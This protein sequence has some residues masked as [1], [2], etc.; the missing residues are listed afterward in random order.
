MPRLSTRLR[1]VIGLTSVLVSA[2]L[3]A[4]VLQIAPD[5]R[6]AEVK[7]R[8]RLCE[9]LAV[10]SSVLVGREDINRVRAVLTVLKARHEDILSAGVRKTDGTL[11][12]D[13]GEHA[14]QWEV[15]QGKLSDDS[16]IYVPLRQ[17]HNDWG[18]LEMK[19][20]PLRGNLWFEIV[21]SRFTHLVL[22][23]VGLCSVTW[24]WFLGRV[25]EQLSPSKAVPG[26]VRSALDTL[27][28]GLLVLDRK[29][30]IVLCN[31]SLSQ[32]LGEDSDKLIGRPAAKLPW[33]T[34][35]VVTTSTSI[36][37]AEELFPW[38]S[39]LNGTQQAS[40]ASL[41]LRDVSGRAR[42]YQVNCAPVFGNGTQI[43]GVVC[44]FEDVTVLES[45]KVELAEA[46]RAKSEFLANMSHEIR[47]PMNAILGFTEVL[48]RGMYDNTEQRAEYLDTIHAS[49]NHLLHLI[50]DIL[51]LSKVESGR[52]ELEV[53]PC[54]PHEILL[55]VSNVLRVRV[56]EKGL[57][58]SATTP[59]GLPEVISSD[60][61][62]LRQVFTNLI[63]NAIK[64]TERGRVQLVARFVSGDAPLISVDVIDSG[65]GIPEKSL[66]KIFEPFTQADASVTRKFGGTGLGLTISK[67]F[68]EALG[69]NVTVSSSVGIGT[70]FTVTIPTGVIDSDVRLIDITEVQA[71]KRHSGP[72]PGRTK[73]KFPAAKIL[74]V[75]DGESNRQLIELILGREGLLVDT[76]TN[77]QEALDQATAKSYDIIFMDMQMPVMD[78]YTA[79]SEL[80]RLGHVEPIIALT[81]NAMKGDEEKCRAAGCTGFLSKPVDLDE[82]L[83]TVAIL[84]DAEVA[85][86]L[87][88]Q[89]NAPVGGDS[90]ATPN[91]LS[92]GCDSIA[93]PIAL[94]VDFDPI[95]TV[96][97]TTGVDANSKAQIVA[98]A[99]SI[100]PS[101]GDASMDFPTQTSAIASNASSIAS[102]ASIPSAMPT[103]TSAKE[104]PKS[105]I[106]RLDAVL[107]MV[108]NVLGPNRS[109]Q[110]TGSSA[111]T[112]TSASIM[113]AVAQKVPPIES[114]TSTDFKP[115]GVTSSES[116]ESL[117]YSSLP[118]DD[119]EFRQIVSGFIEKLRKEV[120]ALNDACER[121]DRDEILRLSHWLKGAAGTMGF[122]CFTEPASVILERTREGRTD[123]VGP[124]LNEINSLAR[125][126]TV[127]D[128]QVQS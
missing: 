49:G 80:R 5:S 23:V 127:P 94:P 61:G 1:I 78:G 98:S 28:E 38:M 126:V 93:T 101:I 41:R 67:R 76:A 10:N 89:L 6:E 106:E 43:R 62:R 55:D 104:K 16:Q 110:S 85:S 37:L 32:T 54:N 64:F 60:P 45:Q 121:A 66:A 122:K 82:L 88:E 19:F 69:G 75:D 48:R 72:K 27:A 120:D 9:A 34:D 3:T 39:V 59:G 99:E 68:V 14:S 4:V 36:G 92:V 119:D 123:G 35:S 128:L 33:M 97:A 51:D 42:I 105:P 26:R 53:I 11:V 95:A 40:S 29:G 84:L 22:F 57:T 107:N 31:Q 125:R 63:G 15:D 111:T 115:I 102:E 116:S 114:A 118:M 77:G 56:E 108:D 81:A 47:T 8:A 73:Y 87:S 91:V 74:L 30:R 103:S 109:T 58:L 90:I 117:I 83:S 24:Y 113:A 18:G 65:V 71:R 13:V 46:S 52:M 79:T 86:D 112:S 7:A 100:N 17:G 50:N 2:M 20:R 124:A 70:T 21:N 44:S 25:L 12:I 96:P